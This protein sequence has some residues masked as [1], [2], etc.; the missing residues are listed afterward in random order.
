[1]AETPLPVDEKLVT[2]I[3]ELAG[4]FSSPERINRA[5]GKIFDSLLHRRITPKEAGTLCYI[6]QT[7]LNSQR[8]VTFIEKSKPRRGRTFINDLP[9]AIRD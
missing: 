2:E 7:I 9:T 1:V 4:D 8:T 6:A 5:M 3:V